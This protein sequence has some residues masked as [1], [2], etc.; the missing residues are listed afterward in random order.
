METNAYEQ[1]FKLLGMKVKDKVTGYSGIVTS[2]S[3]DLYG[4]IQAVV[5]PITGKGN[6]TKNGKWFDVTRLKVTSKK[7]VMAL[8]DFSKGY[9]AEGKKGAAEKP[10]P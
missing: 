6:D 7:P 4:C 10:L 3:F 9:I 8:P 2:L 1:H 5:T